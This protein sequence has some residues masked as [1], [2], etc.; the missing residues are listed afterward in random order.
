M[1]PYAFLNTEIGCLYDQSRRIPTSSKVQGL[2]V[3]ITRYPATLPVRLRQ[4]L[5]WLRAGGVQCPFSESWWNSGK[6]H[7]LLAA[8][9]VRLGLRFLRVRRCRR[10]ISGRGAVHRELFRRYLWLVLVSYFASVKI[11]C[12]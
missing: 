7:K 12:S 4:F 3:S 9:G 11:S 1:V 2:R 6:S 10:R 8:S 5:G